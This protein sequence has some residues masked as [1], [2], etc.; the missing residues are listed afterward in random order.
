MNLQIDAQRLSTR[1]DG[2]A[3]F[4]NCVEW[5]YIREGS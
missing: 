1:R 4:N 2:L 5:H 3:R